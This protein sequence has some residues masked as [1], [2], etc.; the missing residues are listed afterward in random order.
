MNVETK[1]PVT[2]AERL[3][4]GPD[5]SRFRG[6]WEEY[7]D[8][9]EECDFQIEYENEEIILMSIASDP[10]EAIVKNIIVSLSNQL[11]DLPDF[12]IRPSNRH[13][14]IKNLEK[15]YAPDAHV[16]KG[17]PGIYTL[18]KGLTAN[19]NPWLVVE[20]LSP[21]TF[22][23]DMSEKLPAYK[24]ISSL[25]HIIYIHQDRLMV[26]LSSRVGETAIWE[27]VDFDKLEDVFE[28]AEKPIY[29]KDIYKKVVFAGEPEKNGRRK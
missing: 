27:T 26:T 29:L 20:V 19:L 18:R 6:S 13:V 23:R 8:L 9:L 7:L 14:F 21:S 12:H 3:E 1:F 10:H 15:D 2:L 16:V 11:D 22:V 25:R 17:E 4:L 28:L 5:S 24:K